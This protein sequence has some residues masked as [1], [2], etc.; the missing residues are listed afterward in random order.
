M[1]PSALSCQRSRK[2]STVLQI[3]HQ[4]L[5]INQLLLFGTFGH[6][7]KKNRERLMY[8]LSNLLKTY[9]VCFHEQLKK[10]REQ[11]MPRLKSEDLDNFN[12]GSKIVV[13]YPDNL[14]ILTPPKVTMTSITFVIGLGNCLVTET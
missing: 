10:I 6:L 7:K 11:L 13:N 3:L 12:S 5:F 4:I 2:V 9:S 1:A 14:L 8:S